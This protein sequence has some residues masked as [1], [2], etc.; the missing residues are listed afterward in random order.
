MAVPVHKHEGSMRWLSHFRA[1]LLPAALCLK[2]LHITLMPCCSKSATVSCQKKQRETAK[3]GWWTHDRQQRFVIL[4][5]ESG[6]VYG[7]QT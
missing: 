3:S 1:T 5:V 2:Q 4:L 6:M 7:Q